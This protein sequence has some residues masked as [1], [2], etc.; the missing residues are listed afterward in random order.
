MIVQKSAPS[1]RKKVLAAAKPK[2]FWNWLKAKILKI[3][4][5][6]D[7]RRAVSINKSP[8]TPTMEKFYEFCEDK[9][10]SVVASRVKAVQEEELSNVHGFFEDRVQARQ[11]NR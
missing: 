10:R 11:M 3:W 7:F 4:P 9:T 2:A 1:R 5:D 6:R 8:L